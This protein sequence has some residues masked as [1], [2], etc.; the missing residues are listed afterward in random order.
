MPARA[1]GDTGDRRS[2]LVHDHA[3]RLAVT[4]T[5][6]KPRRAKPAGPERRR[7]GEGRNRHSCR[8]LRFTALSGLPLGRAL[9]LGQVAVELPRAHLGDFPPPLL[10]FGFYKMARDVLPQSDPDHIV[11]L[12]FVQRLVQVVRQVVDAKPPALPEAHL[13]YVFIDGLPPVGCG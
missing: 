10:A 6:R 9:V 5:W 11:L 12:Q 8:D 3:C 1:R 4:A 2:S 13:P 7:E